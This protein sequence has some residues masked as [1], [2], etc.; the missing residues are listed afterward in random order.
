[1]MVWVSPASSVERFFRV[2]SL[3]ILCAPTLKSEA[4]IEALLT[5]DGY[6]YIRSLA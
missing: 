5:H 2:S 3:P 6:T 4:I 1:M